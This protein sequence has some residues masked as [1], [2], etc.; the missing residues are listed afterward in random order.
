MSGSSSSLLDYRAGPRTN[1]QT[2]NTNI[3]KTGI[4]IN[5]WFSAFERGK[6]LELNGFTLKIPH[7]GP[8]FGLQMDFKFDNFFIGKILDPVYNSSPGAKC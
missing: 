4:A 7:L 6:G 3:L 5:M 1:K 2:L 8:Y